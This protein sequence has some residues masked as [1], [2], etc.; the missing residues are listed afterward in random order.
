M[1]RDGTDP[2]PSSPETDTAGETSTI[3]S[4]PTSIRRRIVD[5]RESFGGRNDA[6]RY[7]RVTDRIRID[8]RSLAVFRVA[9]GLLVIADLLLRSRNFGF[10]YTDDGVV[11]QE[12]AELYSPD[13]AFSV[14]YF[15][16]DPALIAALFVLQGL[17]AV[18]LIVGFKTRIA[19]VLTFLGVISLDYHNPLVLSYAD[20][21]F[22]LLC[23]WAIFL[24]LGERFSID[25]VQRRRPARPS[26]VSVASALILGQM[27]YMYFR[28][29]LHKRNDSTGLWQSGDAA[30]LVFGLDEMTFLLGDFMRQFPTLIGYGGTM[31]YYM[32][33]LSPLLLLASGRV[34]YLIAFVFVGGH[35]SFALTVRIGAFAYVAMAGLIL[36]LQA[37][38]WADA[39]TVL[40]KF[41]LRDRAD[42]FRH[43]LSARGVAL[44]GAVP[45]VS[46]DSDLHRDLKASLYTATLGVV[47]IGLAIIWLSSGLALAGATDGPIERTVFDTEE[48][49]QDTKASFGIQ[50]PDWSVFA[51]TPRTT[52]RY[53]VFPAETAEGE[54]IDVFNDGRTLTYDRPYEQ[55]QKQHDTYRQRFYMNSI[56]RADDEGDL[57]PK[58][59]AEHLCET[60]EDEH[61]IELVRINI[62]SVSESI[63]METIDAPEHRERTERRHS[64]HACGDVEPGPIAPPAHVDDIVGDTGT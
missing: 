61:G 39:R 28:N 24:P 30:P 49:V 40:S 53:Y 50:Q 55:L 51:P 20:T 27:V 8:T 11:T 18:Q 41:G 31:W 9:I 26:I 35:A 59:L 62:Y 1:D 64:E 21:L 36:F 22:R 44:A 16:S 58:L 60:W 46:F 15:V 54:Y 4:L 12:L 32:M 17:I 56:R 52:D 14:Y 7:E 10:Y 42:K 6:S 2:D 5:A 37:P 38:F 29:G 63:T 33:L 45:T 57:A 25:A 34:R 19:M 43:R 23:F 13:G 3:G 47:V 48:T